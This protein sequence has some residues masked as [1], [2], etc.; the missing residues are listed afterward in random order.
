MLANGNAAPVIAGLA[1]GTALIFIFTLAFIYPYTP[2]H[3]TGKTAFPNPSYYSYLIHLEITGVEETYHV[4]ERIDFA[5]QQRS[6]GCVFPETILLMNKD[7]NQIVWQFNS[8]QGNAQ[9]IGCL[10]MAFDPSKSRMGLNTQ[11]EEPPIIANQTGL[12]AVIAQH[13]HVK[14]ERAFA[15]IE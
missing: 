6:G 13:Q 2:P 15:V 1:S 9:L 14:V 10:S 8:T 3:I 4:G 12:Y 5:V 11:Y 7:T